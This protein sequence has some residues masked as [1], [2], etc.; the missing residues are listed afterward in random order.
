MQIAGV[1]ISKWFYLCIVIFSNQYC[2]YF[3]YQSVHF[4]MLYYH[5]RIYISIFLIL[6]NMFT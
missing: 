6:Q 4:I 5:M 1:F 2:K 3:I